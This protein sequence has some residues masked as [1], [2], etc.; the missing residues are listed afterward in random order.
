MTN[1]DKKKKLAD[2]E[3]TRNDEDGLKDTSEGWTWRRW[4]Q[5]RIG[6][7]ALKPMVPMD[8]SDGWP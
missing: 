1:C 7:L 2:A 8:A 6:C 4:L 5:G 3:R